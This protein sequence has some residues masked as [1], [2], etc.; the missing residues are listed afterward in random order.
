MNRIIGF[1][2]N[3]GLNDRDNDLRLIKAGGEV[4]IE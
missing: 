1:V 3:F 4:K 2:P